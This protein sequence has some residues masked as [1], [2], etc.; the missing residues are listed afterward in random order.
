MIF[1]S[2]V[3]ELSVTNIVISK[4]FYVDILSFK[5]QYEREEDSFAFIS[6]NGAQLM[7]DEGANGSWSTAL[8]TYPFGRG[9]NLQFFVED[10]EKIITSLNKHNIKLFKDPFISNYRIGPEN[11]T[12]KEVLVQDPDGYLLRFSQKI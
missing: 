7:L 5:V 1:N 10:V 11:H 4:S 9:I 12:F 6:L 2:L 3:P 8:T